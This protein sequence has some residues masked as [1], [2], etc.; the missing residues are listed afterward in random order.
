LTLLEE[1]AGPD[2]EVLDQVLYLQQDV[3]SV[4]LAGISRGLD[5]AGFAS[6]MVSLTLQPSRRAQRAA[7]AAAPPHARRC[8]V[9]ASRRTRARVPHPLGL[10]R[11]SPC[12]SGRT[13]KDSAT[14]TDSR[15]VGRAGSAAGRGSGATARAH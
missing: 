12:G 7:P 1:P 14:R 9:A 15:A 13:R 4:S 3:V 6:F 5:G 11:A 10:A 8:R 2:G